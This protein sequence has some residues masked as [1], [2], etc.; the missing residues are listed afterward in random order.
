MYWVLCSHGPMLP[1]S[2][3]PNVICTQGSIV[4]GFFVPKVLCSHGPMF[5]KLYISL[6]LC[7]QCSMFPKFY[8]YWVLCS[9][10]SMFPGF[11]MYWV[12]CSKG[13]KFPGFY[14]T[15]TL[16]SQGSIFPGFFFP[17]VLCSQSSIFPGSYTEKRGLEKRVLDHMNLVSRGTAMFPSS[18][19]LL[20]TLFQHGNVLNERRLFSCQSLVDPCRRSSVYANDRQRRTI[21]K[22]FTELLHF[23]RQRLF[24]ECRGRKN[25]KKLQQQTI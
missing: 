3:A 12:L 10:C 21:A 8:M 16:C 20:I 4:P 19:A 13:P 24:P 9:Q 1:G 18:L 17:Q 6:A 5:P 25:P 11:Y 7:S 14:T 22:I 23:I 2:Y 15:W